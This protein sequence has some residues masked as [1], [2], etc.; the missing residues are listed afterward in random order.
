MAECAFVQPRAYHIPSFIANVILLTLVINERNDFTFLASDSQREYADTAFCGI[1]RNLYPV[2]IQIFSIGDKDKNLE[3]V[4]LIKCAFRDRNRRSDIRSGNRD[5]SGFEDL[6]RLTECVIV[7]RQRALQERGA[8]EGDQA[9]SVGTHFFDKIQHG[10]LRP[11]QTIGFH[12][13]REHTSGCIDGEDNVDSFAFNFFPDVSVLGAGHG[14]HN[15]R[16]AHRK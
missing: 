14:D 12:V 15:Q 3:V 16:D 6:Q 4:F 9:D 2:A 5:D 11:F 13:L 7:E 1:S 8:G 10:Q